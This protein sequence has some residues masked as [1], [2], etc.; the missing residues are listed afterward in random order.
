MAG[1]FPQE[2][3]FGTQNFAPLLGPFSLLR[4]PAAGL[5]NGAALDFLIYRGPVLQKNKSI[6]S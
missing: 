2:R 4:V 6:A 3:R 1:D 5:G